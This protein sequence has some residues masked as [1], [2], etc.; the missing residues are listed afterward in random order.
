MP[1][2]P[3]E[4]RYTGTHWI[5]VRQD[6]W[7]EIQACPDVAYYSVAKFLGLLIELGWAAYKE[8]RRASAG[9]K[10]TTAKERVSRG[11]A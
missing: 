5:N 10:P 1:L 2:K 6:V 8:G 7:D 9:P 4:N 3:Q 11:K